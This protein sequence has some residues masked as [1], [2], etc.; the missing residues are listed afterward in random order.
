MSRLS[1]RD[2]EGDLQYAHQ[3]CNHIDETNNPL[4]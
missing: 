1:A 2:T 4:A 3:K